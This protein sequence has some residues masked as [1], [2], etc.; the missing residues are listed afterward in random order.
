MFSNLDYWNSDYFSYTCK[1]NKTFWLDV[2]GPMILV[3]NFMKKARVVSL[4][5]EINWNKHQIFRLLDYHNL[6]IKLY[7]L[8]YKL[9][10]LTNI[11]II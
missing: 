2:R 6:D 9:A 1:D 7:N 3:S 11:Q 4:L 8:N 10:Y 5:S